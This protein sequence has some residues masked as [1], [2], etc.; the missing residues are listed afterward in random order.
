LILAKYKYQLPLQKHIT[1]N[2]A[3]NTKQSISE[4]FK[5]EQPADDDDDDSTYA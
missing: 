4:L 5:L 2:L 1:L 3:E